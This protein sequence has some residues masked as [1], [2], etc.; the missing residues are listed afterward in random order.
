MKANNKKRKGNK[1]QMK[2]QRR[3]KAA[4]IQCVKDIMR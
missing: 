3:K 4:T 1:G 2:W